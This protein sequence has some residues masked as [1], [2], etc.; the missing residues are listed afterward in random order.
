V[1]GG[2]EV[3]A[4]DRQSLC[5]TLPSFR[6]YQGAV[7]HADGQLKGVVLAGDGG[8]GHLGST[9]A[10]FRAPGKSDACSDG[11]KVQ[12]ASHSWDEA[13]VRAIV[14]AR[15]E[16]HVVFLH[17]S[18]G[19]D[20]KSLLLDVEL[21]HPIC[22]LGPFWVTDVWP[23]KLDGKLSIW[24]KA[25][26]VNPELPSWWA[27]NETPPPPNCVGMEE[28]VGVEELIC[29]AC[30]KSSPRCYEQLWLCLNDSCA[31]FFSD[32]NGIAVDLRSLELSNAFIH[33]R[34]AYPHDASTIPSLI[35]QLPDAGTGT[36]NMWWMR[37][38]AT[39]GV[40]CRGCGQCLPRK[41]FKGWICEECGF[42]FL[43]DMQ[44]ITIN[45]LLGNETPTGFIE[46][47]TTL[48]KTVGTNG[49]WRVTTFAVSNTEKIILSQSNSTINNAPGG[50]DELF[51]RLQQDLKPDLRRFALHNR[52]ST[53]FLASHYTINF[54][55]PYKYVVS[56]DSKPFS[57]APDPIIAVVARLKWATQQAVG[58]SWDAYNEML[59]VGYFAGNKMGFHDDGEK[60]LGPNVSS[61]SL[62]SDSTIAF[63]V[64]K[65]YHTGYTGKNFA[66]RRILK[67]KYLIPPNAFLATPRQ[68]ILD[69]DLPVDQ[70]VKALEAMYDAY[71]TQL[72]QKHGQKHALHVV[73]TETINRNILEFTL[74]HGDM[75]LMSGHNIQ[76]YLEHGVSAIPGLRFALTCREITGESEDVAYVPEGR[77]STFDGLH[78]HFSQSKSD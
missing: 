39:K 21:P 65:K 31:A 4:A 24:C 19:P 67:E 63:R 62:G 50:S 15:A 1:V 25:Q 11:V 60:G 73:Q 2:P 46:P 43:P 38:A 75:V 17:L 10:I 53:E 12:V 77:R 20:K 45:Q 13:A 64:K 72:V 26:K 49:E 35:P 36:D 70:H 8:W 44:P 7:Y 59:A 57:E 51:I 33:Q 23:T 41:W 6:S 30:S 58:P 61:L 40:V 14:N 18:A 28:S 47:I 55:M 69:K 37:Q 32:E 5:E 27:S 66:Q 56:T 29:S 9:A 71:W 16:N 68:A 22:Y 52:A 3:W 76:K 78:Q 54:G 74:R 42:E 48:P 34:R